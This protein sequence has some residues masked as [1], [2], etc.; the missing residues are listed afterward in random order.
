MCGE[1]KFSMTS[2]KKFLFP[3]LYPKG[4]EENRTW[5]IKYTTED[6]TTGKFISKK[7]YGALNLV[8]KAEEREKLA[9]Q[10]LKMMAR[11]EPL[12]KYS[13]AKRK[14]MGQLSH[15]VI[16]KPNFADVIQC[17]NNYLQGR[18]H[19]IE[20]QTL[21]QYQGRVN[22]FGKWLQ[23]HKNTSR[24]IGG[25]TKDDARGFLNYL[26]EDLGL[27]NR[28]YND[29]KL[30][31]GTI[32][33]EYVDEGKI[34]GNPWRRIPNLPG[35]TKHFESYPPEL[36]EKIRNTLPGYDPQL[37]LFLQ[38]IYY[39]AIRPHCELRL[40]KRKDLDFE[41]GMFIIPK[42]LSYTDAKRGVNIYA[43]LLEQYRAAGF[44]TAKPD[45]YLFGLHRTPGETPGS[46]KIFISRWNRY[47]KEHHIAAQ[48][49]LYGS[50]HTGGKA[51]SLLFNQYVTKEHMRHRSME[52][53]EQYIDD[54]D[55]NE[56][57]FLQKD[58]PVF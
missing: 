22:A 32:W 52:S 40:L 20:K 17:C 54:L 50:K 5:F 45:E 28:T 7:Y 30:L 23:S 19:E 3:E 53:T 11:G 12:P 24:A 42:E 37:W 4:R 13:G 29:Y 55:K 47:K 44:E 14:R 33:Q 8:E 31:F 36:R 57:Q 48:Y 21:C 27:S 39:C 43:G 41:K 15:E 46:K 6:F 16:A 58:Y 38:T 9:Q 35:K 1:K 26:K 34:T 2:E 25:I 51:L 18:K 56:L 10:Y 49:K